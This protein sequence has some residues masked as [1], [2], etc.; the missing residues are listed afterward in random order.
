MYVYIFIYEQ[1][2]S[3]PGLVYALYLDLLQVD[4]ARY[5]EFPH[6]VYWCNA[7][8]YRHSP[9]TLYVIW[10]DDFQVILLPIWIV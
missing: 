4:I 9:N 7:H 6:R 10:A 3:H 8:V 2:K 1:K 5:V